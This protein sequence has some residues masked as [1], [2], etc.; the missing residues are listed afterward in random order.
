VRC[1]YHRRQ[2]AKKRRRKFRGRN[3]AKSLSSALA[4]LVAPFLY[5]QSPQTHAAEYARRYCPKRFA[6]EFGDKKER[7]EDA[8]PNKRG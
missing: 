1:E 6:I 2:A 3:G 8:T 4:V 5:G 7:A